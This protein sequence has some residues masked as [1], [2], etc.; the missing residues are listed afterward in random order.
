MRRS[1]CCCALPVIALLFSI[2]AGATT[3]AE[4]T[5]SFNRDIRPLLS[6][7]CFHCHGP[8]AKR[9]EGELRLDEEE[10]VRAAFTAGDLNKSVAWERLNS[11]DPDMHMPPADSNKELKP[12]QLALIRAWIEQGADWEGH[13]AFVPPTK[14]EVPKVK[15]VQRVRNPIDAF[16]LSRLERDGLWA[17]DEAD[18]QRLLRRVTLDLTGLPPTI[19]EID[20]FLADESSGAFEK[21]VDRLLA[22]K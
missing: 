5:V 6:A 12:N 11:D 16:V 7:N 19:Q 1:I 22:S 21:V 3:A 20:D 8:D 10:G 13:W 18:K 4:T 2:D 15:D 14:P 9:R 17:S